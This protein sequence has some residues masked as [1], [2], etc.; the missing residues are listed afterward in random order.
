[1]TPGPLWD[2]ENVLLTA[3]NADLTEDYFDLGWRVFEDNLTKFLAG[4]SCLATE[5]DKASGY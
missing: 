1:M 3:H 5:V 2:C 4:E